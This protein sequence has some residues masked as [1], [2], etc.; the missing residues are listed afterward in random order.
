MMDGMMGGMMHGWMWVVVL[1]L[2]AI[3]IGVG[4]GPAA[5][6]FAASAT[7]KRHVAA[8]PP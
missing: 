8:S 1:L 2:I 6:R 3:A 4:V 5:G 7:M